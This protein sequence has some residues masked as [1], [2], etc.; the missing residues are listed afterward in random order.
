MKLPRKI[1]HTTRNVIIIVTSFMLI[2]GGTYFYSASRNQWWPFIHSHN[3]QQSKQDVLSNHT[4][5]DKKSA[6]TA[7]TN[8]NVDATKTTD[9]IPTNPSLI[10][11]ISKLAQENGAV[12]YEASL[13]DKNQ[14]GTCA[15]EFTSK[16]A[17]P[18]TSTT[19]AKNGTCGPI[20]IP[21]LQF[22]KIGDWNFT[23]RYYTK[24]TQVS[25]QKTL[26]IH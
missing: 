25:A 1:N 15:A 13:N 12:T 19:D 10:L 24:N 18:I 21:E 22:T 4:P 9:Q 6:P 2:G 20:S 3:T 8:S 26:S 17:R 11:T 16:G 14:N 23:L 5:S 7:Q